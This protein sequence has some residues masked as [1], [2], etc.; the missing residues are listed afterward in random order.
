[1]KKFGFIL[2][3]IFI[4][5]FTLVFASEKTFIREYTYKA[6]DYDSKVTARV[7]SLEQ[8]KRL[9]LEEVSVFIKSETDWTKT[10]ELIK[11]KYDTNDFFENKIISITAGITETKILEENW[12]GIDY[13]IKAEITLDPD[14]INSKIENI[15]NNKEKLKELEDVKKRADDALKEI[16]RLKKELAEARSHNEQ[17]ELTDEQ[18][19]LT[20]EYNEEVDVLSA[21]DWFQK[22]YN[23]FLNDDYDKAIKYNQ[24][25]IEINPDFAI[26]YNNMGIA[27]AR[28]E[29]YNKAI[30]YFKKAIEIN[31]DDAEAYYN[32]GLIYA[33]KGNYDKAIEY[34]KKAIEINPDFA[35]AYY[36]M[37]IAYHLKLNYDEAIECYQKAIEINPYYADAYNNMGLAY[38]VKAN[39]DKAIECYHKAIEINPD[40]AEAYYNMG[41]AYRMKGWKISGADNFYKAGL[42]YLEQNNRQEVLQTIDAMKDLT[43]DSPL[44]QKLMD[45]LYEE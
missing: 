19:R 26:A 3:S 9:L 25:A 39:D 16:E 1:M 24:K 42:L 22:G 11:G 8:V 30:E 29:N 5:Y 6:S 40:Y 14:D 44:I 27:Y 31:P 35:D 21:T 7:N 34:Y 33:D 28:K 37:G 23:A 4:F 41:L 17:E 38:A 13:W 32:M 20:D 12:T 36:N 18:E 45:K 15:L 10:E 43:P 2:F